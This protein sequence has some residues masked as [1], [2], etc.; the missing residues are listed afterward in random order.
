[1][2][3]DNPIEWNED[4]EANEVNL[5]GNIIAAKTARLLRNQYLK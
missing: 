2:I 4:K 1:M 3:K 5:K